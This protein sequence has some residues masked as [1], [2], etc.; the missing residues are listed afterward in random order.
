MG[1]SFFLLGV[2][3]LGLFH[4]VQVFCVF[5]AFCWVFSPAEVLGIGVKVFFPLPRGHLGL[6]ETGGGAGSVLLVL[7]IFLMPFIH[8]AVFTVSEL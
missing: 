5:C 3:F 8:K 4:V 6:S 7:C 2:C 1:H